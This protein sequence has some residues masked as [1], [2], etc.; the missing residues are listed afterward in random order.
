MGTIEWQI[1]F[2]DPRLRDIV[3]D[4]LVRKMH[5]RKT[6]RNR[7]EVYWATRLV[8]EYEQLL[9]SGLYNGW[10]SY[11][12]SGVDGTLYAI[13]SICLNWLEM[14]QTDTM[15]EHDKMEWFQRVMKGSG[16]FRPDHKRTRLD[17]WLAR[18]GLKR[19]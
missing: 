10:K 16:D 8:G 3:F 13:A 4:V 17:L 2:S 7:P 18:L 9:L 14:R 19:L 1:R 5:H 15:T 12:A 11:P 6:W